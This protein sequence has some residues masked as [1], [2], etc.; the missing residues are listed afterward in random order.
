MKLDNGANRGIGLAFARKVDAGV[1]NP[2]GR[3]LPGVE[4]I[5][6]DVTSDAEEVLADE[7]TQQVKLGLS[8]E[9]GVY[10]RVIGR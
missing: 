1:R 7:I 2:A 3:Q 5:Q 8:A 6:L 10:L 9:P 4:A